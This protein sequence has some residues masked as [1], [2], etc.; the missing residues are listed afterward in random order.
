MRSRSLFAVAAS[1]GIVVA[2]CGSGATP[3]PS[4]SSAPASVAPSTAPASVTPPSAEPS[5][6]LPTAIGPGEGEL[7]IIVWAGYAEDGSNVK[8]YDWVHPFV[9]ANADCAKVN[10]KTA[11]TSDSMVSLMQGGGGGLYDGVSASGDASNT[12]IARGDVAEVNVDLIPDF[13]DITPF[14]QSPAHNTVGGKH[15]GVSHGWGGNTLMWRTDIVK[16]AP[17]SWDV[18]FDPAKMTAYKGKV[19]AYG[20]SIYVADAALYLKTHSPDLGITDPY[21]LTQAQFDAAIAL[22]KAQHA[23]VGKYWEAYSDEIDNFTTGATVVGTTWP[24]QSNTLK[25]NGVAVEAVVPTE[26]MTGWADTWMLGSKAKHPNCMY[27]WMAW[28][29]TPHVQAQV[30]EYF[31]EAPA[32]PK[33]CAELDKTYGSYG[34]KD[35][36]TLYSVNDKAFYDS[37]SFWKTPQADCGDSR[38]QT[39]VAYD[40]WVTAFQ[41]VKAGS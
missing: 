26:G 34:V 31:G 20:G 8:E 14:L 25:A 33:A 28:M 5:S 10:V 35:F 13:K 3:T 27:K 11:D 16:P 1:L 6:N 24:Y 36:C 4:T 7:D 32:N 41:G 39:C 29:V 23:F 40:K 21:E 12:L 38:G 30:A 2:A 37:I 22:L 18:T 15:Y 9:A 17:T 19:T